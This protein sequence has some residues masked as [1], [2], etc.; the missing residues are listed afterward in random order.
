MNNYLILEWFGALTALMGSFFMA[1][2]KVSLQ[3]DKISLFKKYQTSFAYSFWIISN[4]ACIFLFISQ[5]KYGLLFMNAGGLFV[6]LLGFYQWFSSKPKN[7]FLSMILIVISLILL[8]TSLFFLLL[9]FYELESS[10]AEWFG[11]LLGLCAAFLL[12]SKTDKSFFCWFIW[13]VS[14]FVLLIVTVYYSNYGIAFLQAGFMIINITGAI[15]WYK[16]FRDNKFENL[17]TI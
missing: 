13:G 10:S 14:N 3:S 16:Q 8:S 2:A 11:S 17:T 6:N 7:I 15:K 12:A 9:F 4:V 5:D 1:T